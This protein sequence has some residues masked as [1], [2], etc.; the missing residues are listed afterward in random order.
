MSNEELY[1]YYGWKAHKYGFFEEW[2]KSTSE[3]M[4]EDPKRERSLVS[5][6]VFI[7][8]I[9]EKGKSPVEPVYL[10]S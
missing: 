3:K 10:Q 8:L 4:V 2:Q 9:N 7:K 5:Q 6:D 1:E